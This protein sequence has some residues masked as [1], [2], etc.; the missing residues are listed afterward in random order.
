MKKHKPISS[1]GRHGE[2]IRGYGRGPFFVTITYKSGTTVE[3]IYDERG[4]RSRTSCRSGES[5]AVRYVRMAASDGEVH[6]VSDRPK[7]TSRLAGPKG[8]IPG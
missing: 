5:A 2:V 4:L 8:P 7:R 1:S 6:P 3:E